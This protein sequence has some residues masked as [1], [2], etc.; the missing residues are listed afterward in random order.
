MEDQL[1][2]NRLVHLLP[3]HAK[4]MFGVAEDAWSS[5]DMVQWRQAF[6]EQ[7]KRRHELQV[8]TGDGTVKVCFALKGQMRRKDG[9]GSIP[10]ERS[11]GAWSAEET[12]TVVYSLCTFVGGTLALEPVTGESGA[13]VLEALCRVLKPEDRHYVRWLVVDNAS[14]SLLRLL[15]GSFPNLLGLAMDTL[16]LAL[17]YESARGGKRTGG[18]ILLGRLMRKFHELPVSHSNETVGSGTV[19]EC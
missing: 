19:K 10:A 2:G 15:R 9:G 5:P 11:G 3:L 13:D 7:M 16:H 1:A 4:S 12:N 14:P 17:K 6:Y 8:L 18:S